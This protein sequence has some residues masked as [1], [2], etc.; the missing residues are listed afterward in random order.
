MKKVAIIGTVG[1]PANYGGF[2]TLAQHL[3]KN[4]SHKY[5]F[6]VYCSAKK[7]KKEQRQKNYFGARLKFLPFNANGIQSIV[8]DSVSIIHSLF[9]AD[10]L[11]VLGVAGA[12]LLPFVRL[13]RNKRIIISIDGIEWKRDKW[14]TPARLYLWW[15]EKIA[16]KYSHIDISDN[17]SIQDYTARR[18]RSLSRV[19]EYGGDHVQPIEANEDDHEKYWFLRFVYAIKVCRIEPENNVHLILKA[20]ANVNK[21]PLVIIGNWNNSEYGR[22]LKKEYG[23]HENIILLDPIYDQKTLDLLRVNASLYVHGHSAGGTNPSL[24]EAM[25]LGLPVLSYDVSYN[26][27]TSENKAAYFKKE[28]DIISFLENTSIGSIKKIG[29]SMKEIAGR[30]YRWELIAR[31]YDALVEEVLTV[32]VKSHVKP[33]ISI[34]LSHRDLLNFKVAHLTYQY[35]FYDKAEETMIQK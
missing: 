7:Y 18:Y 33:A 5:N 26:R 11:I 32:N 14:N 24:V 8:Y 28:E 30:R 6:T 27:T 2:E 20:F 10:V 12:W 21:Y 34:S 22:L 4:L 35:A 9:Y 15:A 25:S 23:S 13:F 16:V 3:V 31:K 29:T 17:E 19:I 1:L